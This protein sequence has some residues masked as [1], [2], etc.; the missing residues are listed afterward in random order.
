MG[1]QRVPELRF[2][3]DDSHVRGAKVQSLLEGLQAEQGS[4]AAG[5]DS[6][7][8]EDDNAVVLVK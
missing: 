1:L 2:Y 7:D 5:G 6:S 8:E 3:L 4:G